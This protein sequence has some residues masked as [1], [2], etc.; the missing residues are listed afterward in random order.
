MTQT[1]QETAAVASSEKP[2]FLAAFFD[3]GLKAIFTHMGQLMSSSLVI[4]AGTYTVKRGEDL[5]LAGL[6][7]PV[8][9]GY[10]LTAAGVL[11]LVLNFFQGLYLLMKI[12]HGWGWMVLLVVMYVF[13][14]LRAAQ[15]FVAFRNAV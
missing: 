6:F 1:T 14:S 13:L 2:G 10:V 5:H 7:N 4:A 9:A 12:R 3:T 15:L 11:L 8:Q